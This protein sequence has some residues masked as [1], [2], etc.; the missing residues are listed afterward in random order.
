MNLSIEKMAKISQ[1]F[2]KRFFAAGER[3]YDEGDQV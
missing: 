1:F 3:V 2:E